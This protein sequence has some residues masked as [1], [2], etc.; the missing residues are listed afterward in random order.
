MYYTN[1]SLI[2]GNDYATTAS[3]AAT[4]GIIWTILLVIFGIIEVAAIVVSLI[5]MWKIFKKAG[6]NGWEVLIG[7]HD[8]F[9]LCE[10]VNV[11]PLWSLWLIIALC[12][13]AIPFV[14]WLALI[15]AILILIWLGI[16]L[17]KACGKS[18]FIGVLAGIPGIPSAIGLAIIAFKDLKYTKPSKQ[19][20]KLFEI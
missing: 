10:I 16:R 20:N 17:A 18:T 4:F 3:A 9:A 6:K 5:A 7:G 12:A 11:N 14:G 8:A 13:S 1:P 2:S 19:S 15:F